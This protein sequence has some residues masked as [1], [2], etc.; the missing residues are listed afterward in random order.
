MGDN[1]GGEHTGVGVKVLGGEEYVVVGGD[2]GIAH[3]HALPEL[4]IDSG[5]TGMDPAR[6]TRWPPR[7]IGRTPRTKGVHRMT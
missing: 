4:V 5:H 7:R 3:R 2:V 6:R 1:V